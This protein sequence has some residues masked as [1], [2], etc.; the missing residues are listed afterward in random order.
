VSTR[1]RAWWPCNGARS[2]RIRGIA[3]RC[4]RFALPICLTDTLF[5]GVGIFVAQAGNTVALVHRDRVVQKALTSDRASIAHRAG[6]DAI[7]I[8]ADAAGNLFYAAVPQI[9]AGLGIILACFSVARQG[10]SG[11]SNRGRIPASAVPSG[12]AR[13]VPWSEGLRLVS[14]RFVSG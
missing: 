6:G 14:A 7:A 1:E 13:M 5:S 12:T 8:V 2:W 9:I 3:R 10:W 4:R 11:P